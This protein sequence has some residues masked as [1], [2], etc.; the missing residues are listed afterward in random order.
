MKILGLRFG[1]NALE[2][3]QSGNAGLRRIVQ[4]GQNEAALFICEGPIAPSEWRVLRHHQDPDAAIHLHSDQP[5]HQAM[6]DGKPEAARM[7]PPV[8]TGQMLQTC[9]KID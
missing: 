6:S 4:N 7:Y 8:I 1:G 9:R 3:I 5:V 2:G